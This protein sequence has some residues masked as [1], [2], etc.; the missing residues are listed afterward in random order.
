V[1]LHAAQNTMTFLKQ[2]PP[3]SA[4]TACL[5]C[6]NSVPIISRC[7]SLLNSVNLIFPKSLVRCPS[8][9]CS[10]VPT[11][12]EDVSVAPQAN[13][14]LLLLFWSHFKVGFTHMCQSNSN[15]VPFGI[16]CSHVLVHP[17]EF[18]FPPS[19]RNQTVLLLDIR[20]LLSWSQTILFCFF[21]F[22]N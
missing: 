13:Q 17:E 1:L 18:L 5:V 3:P 19:Y 20:Q 6:K 22:S 11:E 7:L 10:P 9:W 2:P 16:V 15:T 8:Q 4:G 21:L 14:C 12:S